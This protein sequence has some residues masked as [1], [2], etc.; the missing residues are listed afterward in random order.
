MRIG[1]I[2]TITINKPTLKESHIEEKRE[3]VGSGE[4]ISKRSEEIVNIG[5]QG[6]SAIKDTIP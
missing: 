1:K 2:T 3:W 4:G 6:P 5:N